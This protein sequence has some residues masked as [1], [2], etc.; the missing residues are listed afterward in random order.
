MMAFRM[1]FKNS[2]RSVDFHSLDIPR[3]IK[4]HRSNIVQHLRFCVSD[5]LSLL[6][7]LREWSMTKV[8]EAKFIFLIIQ[9]CISECL[10]G[11]RRPAMV[12]VF[13]IPRCG[14]N[15]STRASL[16]QAKILTRVKVTS[17]LCVLEVL[18]ESMLVRGGSLL[19]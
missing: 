15:S 19:L 11:L 4:F 6:L 16:L 5:V 3:N 13:M 8:S 2:P 14:L 7:G 1:T 12:K 18:M 17:N 10:N 9:F